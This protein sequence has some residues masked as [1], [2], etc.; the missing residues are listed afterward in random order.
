MFR[1]SYKEYDNFGREYQQ[2]H[3]LNGDRVVVDVLV[4]VVVAVVI[5]VIVVVVFVVRCR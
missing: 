4:G 5:I 3:P 2:T 1:N